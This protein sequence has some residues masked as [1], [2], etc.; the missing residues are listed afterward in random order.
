MRN[1]ISSFVGRECHFNCTAA[2]YG[3]VYAE[4]SNPE[5]MIHVSA[6]NYEYDRPVFLQS[7]F[8][9]G[10]GKA[11]RGDFNP[12]RRILGGSGGRQRCC[13]KQ[14]EGET[15]QHEQFLH[16]ISWLSFLAHF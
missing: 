14:T 4:F 11:P 3:D 12:L 16:T 10:E 2:L 13:C 5:S 8:A 15:Q 1:E 9:G 6:C 7:E